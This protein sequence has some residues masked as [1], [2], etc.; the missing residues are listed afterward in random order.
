MRLRFFLIPF[1]FIIVFGS[2]YSCSKSSGGGYGSTTAPAT[3]PSI[4]PCISIK[5]GF[6]FWVDPR[7]WEWKYTLY[8][9]SLDADGK[10]AC[11][12]GC[13]A[14]WPVSYNA[15]TTSG[16]G[17]TASDFSSITRSDGSKQTTY[18]GWPLYTFREMQHRVPQMAMEFEGVWFVAKPDYSVMLAVTQ[19]VGN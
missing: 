8:F 10:S 1:L 14:V 15:G 13:L 2:L 17:L 12:A 5:N 6:P 19:L 11:T 9:F 4:R 18:K 16:A 7:R 3:P